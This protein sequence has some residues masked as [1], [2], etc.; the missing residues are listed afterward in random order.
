MTAPGWY[1]AD[2]DP[3]GT[4]RYW[5]G[6]GWVG[7][8]R[9]RSESGGATPPTASGGSATTPDVKRN[10]AFAVIATGVLGLL[11]S[12]GPWVSFAGFTVGGLD[13]D[14]TLVL[15]LAIIAA[16]IA[17][18]SLSRGRASWMSIVAGIAG[19]LI[20]LIVLVN[21]SDV[22]TIGAG[23]GFY[24]SLVSGILMAV[25]GFVGDRFIPES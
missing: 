21:W 12:I 14:G 2:G 11:G 15:I 10:W 9:T 16:G 20:V 3:E 19:V 4:Q 8:P 7:D 23:W 1:Y 25:V 17:G 6:N 13:G 18:A 24:L 22:T 5:D